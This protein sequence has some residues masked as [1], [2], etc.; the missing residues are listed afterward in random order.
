M[1]PT[2]K[3]NTR[4]LDYKYACHNMYLHWYVKQAIHATYMLFGVSMVTAV[5]NGY[6]KALCSITKYVFGDTYSIYTVEPSYMH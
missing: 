4:L 1:N 2:M 5:S 3:I 6:L